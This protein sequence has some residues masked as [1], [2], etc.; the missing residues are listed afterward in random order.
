MTFTCPCG[1]TVEAELGGGYNL[2]E[3]R[4][5]TGWDFVLCSGGNVIW[6]C[7]PCTRLAADLA[8]K[9][10]KVVGSDYASFFALTAMA[11][12]VDEEDERE[13]AE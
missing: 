3:A 8:K 5:R 2:G 4:R 10:L 11:K 13:A 6:L 1:A 7:P 9:L 12:R